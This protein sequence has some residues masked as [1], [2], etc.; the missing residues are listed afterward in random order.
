[1]KRTVK[2]LACLAVLAVVLLSCAVTTLADGSHVTYDGSAREF[3][4]APGSDY[5]PTDLFSAFKGVMPGDSVTQRITV[6]NR[7]EK[8]VKIKVY[9]R[10]LGAA[11]G[12]EELLSRLH[13]TVEQVGSSPLFDA[14]AH[15]TAQLTDW[16]YLGTVYSGGR[17][18]L[19]VMLSV[20]LSLEDRFQEAVGYLDWQFKVEELPVS[21]DDPMPP[22]TGDAFVPPVL[23][24]LMVGSALG[25]VTLWL[26]V[27]GRKKTRTAAQ[28]AAEAR[29]GGASDERTGSFRSAVRE[30]DG[31]GAS[32]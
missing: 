2:G 1:M 12:S 32:R 14:P 18:D 9:M 23:W 15:R 13:L 3:I 10:S 19:D 25:G 5:S 28:K 26:A 21:P 16:A 11:E 6:E 30:P 22:Q 20:P 7:Q 4:F 8:N 17:I 31:P 29:R 27:S 24:A